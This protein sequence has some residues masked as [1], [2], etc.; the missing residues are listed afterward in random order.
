MPAPWLRLAP[1]NYAPAIRWLYDH[2]VSPWQVSGA[3]G[4][5]SAHGH[6]LARRAREGPG[7]RHRRERDLSRRL[8]GDAESAEVRLAEVDDQIQSAVASVIATSDFG[9]GLARLR[10][11]S[12][13]FRSPRS[14]ELVELT[15]LWLT[16]LAWCATHLGFSG[17]ALRWAREASAVWRRL[18]RDPRRQEAWLLESH[19]RLYMNQPE[20]SLELLD[21]ASDALAAVPEYHRQYGTAKLL[22]LLA[23]R[24]EPLAGPLPEFPR[25]V[26]LAAD[27]RELSEAER[28]FASRQ[29]AVWACDPDPDGAD[30]RVVAVAAWRG[31]ESLYDV[32]VE[33]YAAEAGLSVGPASP[34]FGAALERLDALRS[35]AE[36]FP[37]QAAIRELLSVTPRLRLDDS[38]TKLWVRSVRY[39]NP[40]RRY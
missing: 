33:N 30:A 12:P 26:A 13:V 4:V 17:S 35:R 34:H 22:T 19:V 40:W 16:S 1:P 8:D 5:T 18:G 20:L 14:P 39:L 29:H 7:G 25:A 10:R 21:A 32:I 11:L 31:G 28:Q 27:S 3:F 6:M 24:R 9:A 38:L 15:G 37:H 36:R 23:A 2:G